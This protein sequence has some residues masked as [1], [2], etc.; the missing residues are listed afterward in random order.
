MSV[1]PVHD[2][3]WRL[4]QQLSNSF[5]YYTVLASSVLKEL[6]LTCVNS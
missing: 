4:L 6:R 5:I 2:V 3:D 1:D